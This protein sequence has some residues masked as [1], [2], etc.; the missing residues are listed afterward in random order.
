M[1]FEFSSAADFDDQFAKNVGKV[2]A[3]ILKAEATQ[4]KRPV[5]TRGLVADS[6]WRGTSE[7]S[8][9]HITKPGQGVGFLKEVDLGRLKGKKPYFKVW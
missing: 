4:A 9:I 7:K 2:Y 3:G 6:C 1:N 8:T 5:L